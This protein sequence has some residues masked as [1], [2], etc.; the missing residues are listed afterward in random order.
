MDD[1]LDSAMEFAARNMK[2]TWSEAAPMSADSDR[3]ISVHTVRGEG[4]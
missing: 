2:I 4:P 3:L 1:Q